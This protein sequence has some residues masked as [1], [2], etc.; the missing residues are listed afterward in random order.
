MRRK[1][2]GWLIAVVA[3]VL[4][5][6]ALWGPI[7]SNVE[8]PRY[9]VVESSGNIEVRDYAPMIVAEAEVLGDR[10]NALARA[11]VSSPITFLGIIR[12]CRR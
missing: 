9:Q 10:P 7:M 4:L 11:S 5:G 1:Y 12:R 8:Q 3:V 6:A 2:M